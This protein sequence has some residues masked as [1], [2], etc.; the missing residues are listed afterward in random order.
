MKT[1][2]M[3]YCWV[4]LLLEVPW[5]ILL[6]GISI[7]YR[8][9]VVCLSLFPFSYFSFSAVLHICARKVSQLNIF[10]ID[11]TWRTHL[12]QVTDQYKKIIKF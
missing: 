2:V 10:P 4:I 3:T 5:N 6:R 7:S 12:Y 9:A 8:D 1:I 11:L